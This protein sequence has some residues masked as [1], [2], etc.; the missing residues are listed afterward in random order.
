MNVLSQS[1][2]EMT[3]DIYSYTNIIS[4][5]AVIEGNGQTAE[6]LLNELMAKS[7]NKNHQNRSRDTFI[8]N[9]VPNTLYK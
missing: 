9:E 3:P 4:G 8:Y 2:S 1:H 6:M 5:Y 7:G